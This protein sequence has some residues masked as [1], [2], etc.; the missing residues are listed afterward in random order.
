VALLEVRGVQVRFGGVMAVGGV[1]LDVE[2]GCVT[3]LIG[4]NGAGKTTLFNVVTGV[5][6]PTAGRVSIDGRDI[7]NAPA[8]RRARHG[9]ARTFQRLELFASL[10]VADNVRVAVELT[11]ER[12]VTARVD[13]L[14][15]RVGAT[16]HAERRAGDLPTG[17]ARMVEVARALATRPQVLLLDE[18]ASGLDD[19]ET[20]RFGALLTSLAADGLAVLVVEHDM[21]LVMTVCQ[22]IYVLDLG[23]VIAHGSPHAVQ[24][25]HAVLEAYLG[26]A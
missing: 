6:E 10:S 25:D 7:T 11:P 23:R 18:P 8:F 19:Q 24:R 4:P 14:L 3:G 26:V 16:E 9:L 2:A 15:A 5:Q 21:S 22:D 1:D 20:D 12:D 13:A 17:T